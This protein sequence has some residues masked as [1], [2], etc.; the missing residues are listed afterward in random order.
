LIERPELA[1]AGVDEQRNEPAKIPRLGSATDS[2][3]ATFP[4]VGTDRERIPAEFGRRRRKFIGL[5]PMIASGAPFAI[6]WRAVS[7]PIPIVPPVTSAHLPFNLSIAS[8]TIACVA[9]MVRHHR[10]V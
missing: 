1:N 2:C 10:A 8:P 9:K 3:A 4:G 6:N 5:V 7:K